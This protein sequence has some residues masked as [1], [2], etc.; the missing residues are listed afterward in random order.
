MAKEKLLILYNEEFSFLNESLLN[1]LKNPKK[2]ELLKDNTLNHCK[3]NYN[4]NIFHNCKTGKYGNFISLKNKDNFYLICINCKRCY[5]KN[6]IELHCTICNKEYYGCIFKKIDIGSY[7]SNNK[8]IYLSTWMKYHCGL[9]NKE[10]MRC[11]QCKNY[12]YYNFVYNDL[13]CYLL[14]VHIFLDF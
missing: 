14:E 6:Y 7:K 5:K 1:Y 9:I 10:I 11:I 4:K 13:E 8:D 2:Y 3:Q 12:F